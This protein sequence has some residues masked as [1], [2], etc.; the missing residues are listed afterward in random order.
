MARPEAGQSGIGGY[1]QQNLCCY[2]HFERRA[3]FWPVVEKSSPL[4]SKYTALSRD[5]KIARNKLHKSRWVT[6]AGF[7]AGSGGCALSA[8]LLDLEGV[9]RPEA[10]QSGIEGVRQSKP[11]LLLSFRA[12]GRFLARSREIFPAQ[13]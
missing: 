10:G 12:E 7:A 6:S 2:C 5:D 13:K 8:S 9:A 1:V 11:S 4:R 3:A